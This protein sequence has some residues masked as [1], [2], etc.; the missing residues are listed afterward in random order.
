MIVERVDGEF[1]RYD[2]ASTKAESS[3]FTFRGGHGSCR[4]ADRE[5]YKRHVEDA[6]QDTRARLR[7]TGSTMMQFR[8]ERAISVGILDL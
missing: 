5:R 3:K 2:L 8:S 1:E 6:E 4:L 7:T